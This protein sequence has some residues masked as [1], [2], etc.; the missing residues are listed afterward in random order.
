MKTRLFTVVLLSL[1]AAGSGSAQIVR[2][3]VSTDGIDNATCSKAA[4]CR[5]FNAAINA[6]NTG[7]EVVA[8]ESGGYGA[9]SITGAITMIAP[10]G[11]HAAIAPTSGAAITVNAP[12]ANVV[13]R[14]LF[15]NGQG[16]TVGIQMTNGLLDVSDMAIY[17]FTNHGIRMTGGTRLSAEDIDLR[18][19][20]DGGTGMTP[21][22]I[23]ISSAGS[24]SDIQRVR[25][26]NSYSGIWLLN[27]IVT[28]RDAVAAGNQYGF[29]A[30]GSNARLSLIECDATNSS[31][32]GL[33]ADNNGLI[34]LANSRVFGNGTSLNAPTLIKS[35]GN[36]TMEE[37]GINTLPT[38]SYNAH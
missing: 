2:T 32:F 16:A 22:A 10:R 37:N 33:Y 18:A 5:T 27:G 11:I 7:G 1:L 19:N 26:L 13:L 31:F 6:V 12:A 36:N 35:L 38:G 3:F 14:G 29:I 28:A 25:L 24:V 15:L 4:P 20:F 8:L 21:G 9:A 34:Y 17:N 23:M 30:S